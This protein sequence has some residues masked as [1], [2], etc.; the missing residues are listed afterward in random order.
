MGVFYIVAGALYINNTS[1]TFLTIWTASGLYIFEGY[2]AQFTIFAGAMIVLC[3]V[4]NYLWLCNVAVPTKWAL[5][6]SSNILDMVVFGLLMTVGVITACIARYSKSLVLSNVLSLSQ[7]YT[8]HQNVVIALTV[9]SFV[10][11]A[12]SLLCTGLKN[13]VYV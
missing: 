13:H 1:S 9:T 12:F 6:F 10:G 4:I 7:D 5:G 3:Q 11:C 2:L 8:N